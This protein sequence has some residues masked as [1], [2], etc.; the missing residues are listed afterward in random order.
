MVINFFFSKVV[1]MMRD[2]NCSNKGNFA[3]GYIMTYYHWYSFLQSHYYQLH[4]FSFT[5]ILSCIFVSLA[6]HWRRFCIDSVHRR[7][8][9]S[10]AATKSLSSPAGP[11][12]IRAQFSVGRGN[13]VASTHWEEPKSG[14]GSR[15][16]T[17]TCS[18]IIHRPRRSEIRMLGSGCKPI[19]TVSYIN[20]NFWICR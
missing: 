18:I 5:Y 3:I 10:A 4:W 6:P 14:P 9:S 19:F 2:K 15:L 8:A 7:D 1:L 12:K 11:K 13:F 17:T 20:A 16:S